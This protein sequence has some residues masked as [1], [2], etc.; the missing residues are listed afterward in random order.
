MCILSGAG[1]RTGIKLSTV[2]N[3]VIAPTIAKLLGIKYP[4]VDG[5]PLL[6]AIQTSD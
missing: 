5:K 3:T 4:V 1:I 2:D 6:Q